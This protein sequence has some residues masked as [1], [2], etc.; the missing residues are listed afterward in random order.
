MAKIKITT[1]GVK[2]SLSNYNYLKA[3][4]EY[5][6]NG[7]DADASMIEINTKENS[8][9]RIN[10]IIIKDNGTGI[11]KKTLNRTFQ[12]FYES[13][14][15]EENSEKTRITGVHGKN[16]VGRLTF[17]CFA[18]YAKWDT[19]YK[20]EGLFKGYSIKIDSDNLEEYEVTQEEIID[21]EYSQTIVTLTE[22]SEIID[23][24]ELKNYIKK[25]FACLLELNKS[26][27]YKIILNGELVEYDCIILDREEVEEIC[28]ELEESNIYTSIRYIQWRSNLSNE[29]SRYYFCDSEDNFKFS[30]T[31]TLNKKGD[32]FYHSVFVKSNL[33]DN[34]YVSD[35]MDGQI[36]IN[37]YN[38]SSKEFKYLKSEIDKYLRE[39]RKPHIINY[40]NKLVD[41]YD[42]EGIF[43]IYNPDNFIDEY[44]HT[45]LVNTVKAVCQTEPKI[46]AALNNEQKKT[47]VRLFDL[48]IQS[49]EN[50]SLFTILDEVLNLDKDEKEELVKALNYSNLSNITRTIKLIEDR[51]KAIDILKQLVYKEELNANERDHIQKFIEEHYWLFGEKYTLVTAA[52]PRFEKALRNYIKLLTGEESDATINHEDKNKEMDIFAVRQNIENDTINNI[53]VELKSPKVPLG[54]KQYDQ[55]YKYMDVISKQEQFNANNATWEFY[56]I[57]NKLDNSGYIEN[58]FDNA[59]GHGEK[60][61]AYKVKNYK[62][63]IKTWS[64]IINEFEIKHNFLQD[65]LKL[66]RDKIIK[67]Y[68]DI[69]N[70]MEE[71]NNSA[72]EKNAVNV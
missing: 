22:F 17:F 55:V 43:P 14:K 8:L 42:E 56:L 3:I 28:N 10:T 67:E 61:L 45:Q 6:W 5:I 25:E 71:S 59:K 50:D 13:Q 26:K 27:N 46:F 62:I 1:G 4:C 65:R 33:F 29:Y 58:L 38:K 54:K 48:I 11:S 21:A 7:F 52:E 68:D 49:G 41:K 66:D 16:G 12:P 40:T 35:I 19:I 69:N 63:Y 51:Y 24:L 31:T 44:K 39:K 32:D 47:L 57:G 70:A 64:E 34:F 2:Q 36:P 20:D 53:V 9:N 30:I 60:F 72:A 15:S 37:G 23:I 18:K